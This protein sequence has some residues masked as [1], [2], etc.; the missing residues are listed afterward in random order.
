MPVGPF[1]VE[2]LRVKE[3]ARSA[4]SI[5]EEGRRQ[6]FLPLT[7][8]RARSFSANPYA[9]DEDIGLLLVYSKDR[10]VGYLAIVPG[11]IRQG[12]T[13]HKIYWLSSWYVL[14]EYRKAGA[15]SILLMH[16]LRLKYDLF[17][18]GNTHDSDRVFRAGPFQEI[19]PLEF[20][21]VFVDGLDI[22]GLPFLA[23]SKA[24]ERRGHPSPRLSRMASGSRRLIYPGLKRAFYGLAVRQVRRLDDEVILEPL[25]KAVHFAD[26]WNH[27][28]EEFPRFL[29]GPDAVDWMLQFPWFSEDSQERE[30]DYYFGNY[31]SLFR[32]IPVAFR[33][34]QTRAVEG[35]AVFLVSREQGLTTLRALDHHFASM[36]GSRLL[37][38]AALRHAA[39]Y[40]ADRIVLPSVCGTHLRGVVRWLLLKRKRS[41]FCRVRNHSPIAL[42]LDELQLHLADGDCAFS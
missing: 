11:I 16:A 17:M 12:T 23:L 32:Y 18:T 10:C 4:R 21:M 1:R 2:A 39:Q 25:N 24:L 30:P 41:C 37:A 26:L 42:L 15:G 5:L 22:T 34:I 14:P 7:E 35:V 28:E 6:G 3:I 36:D 29:R 33:N 13:Q 19:P 20:G 38:L 40:Q 27:Q 8:R 31:R 9:D